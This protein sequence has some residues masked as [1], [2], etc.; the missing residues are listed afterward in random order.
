MTFEITVAPVY[1]LGG[2]WR[3]QAAWEAGGRHQ[4]AS[5][6][7]FSTPAGA[8]AAAERYCDRVADEYAEAETYL[9]TP[10]GAG[11]AR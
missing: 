5:G 3:W 1:T 4:R 11:Q 6:R 9:Y 2:A 10:A 7:G 8:R